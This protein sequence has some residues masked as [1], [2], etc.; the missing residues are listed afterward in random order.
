MRYL[1]YFGFA[2]L[3]ILADQALKLYIHFTLPLDGDIPIFGD[4][5]KLHH[6]LNPGM[7]FGIELGSEYG[8]LGLTIFR[9]LAVVVIGYFLARAIKERQ[10]RGLLISG[11]AIWGGALG[12]VIDSTFYGVFIEGNA[13][14]I[15]TKEP[16]FYPWFH[17]QVIDMFYFDIWKGYFP[18]YIPIW[19]G[20]YFSFFPIF[21][22]ADAAIFCGVLAV[23]I[24]HKRFFPHVAEAEEKKK[25]SQTT[26]EV[27]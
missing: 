8:K 6:T 21:N 4:W 16:P 2:V 27:E 3:L 17:G 1:L 12:N 23:L 24:W 15:G 26:Q 7:A 13:T 5:F 9:A 18:E 19:G 11:A 25:E 14:P 20:Q 22:I 10:P